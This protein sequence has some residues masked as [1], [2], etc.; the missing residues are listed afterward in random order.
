MVNNIKLTKSFLEFLSKAALNRNFKTYRI[1]ICLCKFSD[2]KQLFVEII[3]NAVWFPFSTTF[4]RILCFFW[5]NYPKKLS[6]RKDQDFLRASKF[7]ETDS[8][9]ALK[10]DKKRSWLDAV[11]NGRQLKLWIIRKPLLTICQQTLTTR[12]LN[13]VSIFIYFLGPVN[14]YQVRKWRAE[15]ERRWLFCVTNVYGRNC[16]TLLRSM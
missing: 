15:V 13:S 1:W 10:K 2:E 6:I 3:S 7:G 14:H 4:Q 16:L 9:V 12:K 8:I 11:S 5:F